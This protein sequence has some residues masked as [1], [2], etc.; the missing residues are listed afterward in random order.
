MTKCA[1]VWRLFLFLFLAI[2]FAGCS[3]FKRSEYAD[4]KDPHYLEGKRR[5]SGKDWTGAIQSFERALRSN[6]NNAAAHLE[7][8][9]IYGEIK[10]DFA[11]AVYHYQKHLTLYTNSPR[12]DAV[13]DR[14]G[15]CK[16][17]LANSHAFAVV[18]RDIQPQL[19]RLIRTNELYKKRIDLLEAELARGPRYITNYVTNFVTV[20]TNQQSSRA[21]TRSTIIVDP[22]SRP[23]EPEEEDTPDPEPPKPRSVASS[24]S[25]GSRNGTSTQRQPQT[26]TST[27]ETRTPAPT[28]SVPAASSARARTVHTVR[29]GDTLVVIAR[30]YGVTT[31]QL[32]A[33]NPGLGSGTRAGQKITIPN[34]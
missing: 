27:R 1:P 29:P 3:Q 16:R 22:P 7:L 13:I 21:L 30:R 32:R 18:G 2:S 8:G 20:D 6:P 25:S 31:A 24:G 14:I 28:R 4:E 15:F 26:R 33:A 17:E 11:S 9:L 5:Q 10:S 12:R 23:V 19:D 34:K